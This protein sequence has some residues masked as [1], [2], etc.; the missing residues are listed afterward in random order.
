MPHTQLQGQAEVRRR[1]LLQRLTNEFNAL[2]IPP[3][4]TYSCPDDDGSEIVAVMK[5]THH[6]LLRL[7]ITLT[8]CPEARRGPLTR[9]ALGHAGEALIGE[10]EHIVA[11]GPQ[12][13]ATGID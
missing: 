6:R 5:Y 12:P 1:S 11:A 2:P 7:G 8:G 13:T 4:G 10:L 9:S 3:K